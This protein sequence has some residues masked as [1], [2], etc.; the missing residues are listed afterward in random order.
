M[1]LPLPD[2][3]ILWLYFYCTFSKKILHVNLQEN[4]STH[5]SFSFAFTLF[6]LPSTIIIGKDYVKRAES[7]VLLK[8]FEFLRVFLLFNSERKKGEEEWRCFSAS[9]KPSLWRD[10]SAGLA[11][12]FHQGRPGMHTR[13][14]GQVPHLHHNTL[15]KSEPFPGEIHIPNI[16]AKNR[17]D[18]KVWFV[19]NLDNSTSKKR[20]FCSSSSNSNTSKAVKY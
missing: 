7:A 2:K 5:T 3:E 13:K 16:S 20:R 1:L 10:R 11:L 18:S 9:P 12:C 14:R 4:L 8:H 15:D 17:W 19:K 6:L